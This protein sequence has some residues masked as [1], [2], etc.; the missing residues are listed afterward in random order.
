MDCEWN[1]KQ[2]AVNVDKFIDTLMQSNANDDMQFWI[3][4]QHSIVLFNVQMLLKNSNGSQE[5]LP[6]P[7]PTPFHVDDPYKTIVEAEID[8]FFFNGCT[9]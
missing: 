4:Q 7:P 5:T 3:K 8:Y 9:G 2:T 6:P 1:W